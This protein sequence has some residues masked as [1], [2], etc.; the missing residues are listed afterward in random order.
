[1]PKTLVTYWAGYVPQSAAV[2]QF[3]DNVV[4]DEVVLAFLGPTADSVVETTFITS[5]H[6]DNTLIGAGLCFLQANNP[7]MRLTISLLDTPQRHWSDL[8]FNATVLVDSLFDQIAD[9]ASQ[10]GEEV[11]E[12]DMSFDIDLETGGEFSG[13][14]TLIQ[15]LNDG[16]LVR[17]ITGPH[18]SLV[19]YTGSDSAE[20]LIDLAE[21]YAGWIGGDLSRVCVLG[22]VAVGNDPGTPISVMQEVVARCRALGSIGIWP[23]IDSATDPSIPQYATQMAALAQ[24]QLKLFDSQ[25]AVVAPSS[26]RMGGRW[27]EVNALRKRIHEERLAREV[28]LNQP[29]SVMI[30]SMQFELIAVPEPSMLERIWAYVPAVPSFLR[31]Y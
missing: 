13:F 6:W 12:L 28:L 31:F 21:R 7:N 11:C 16:L 9:W 22:A 18:I 14:L 8:A 1:M 17:N 25:N 5:N 15:A 29:P 10:N 4:P 26:G 30:S 20:G 23:L 3:P 19:G 2:Q 27:H 24:G